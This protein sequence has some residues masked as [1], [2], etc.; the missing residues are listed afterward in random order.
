LEEEGD[1]FINV[2]F[3]DDSNLLCG[4]IIAEVHGSEL[5]SAKVTTDGDLVSTAMVES[6]NNSRLEFES[7]D[8]D[9]AEELGHGKRKSTENKLYQSFWR[10]K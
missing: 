5:N 10:H 2:P 8:S 6:L 3:E 1:D 4:T 9:N 7:A